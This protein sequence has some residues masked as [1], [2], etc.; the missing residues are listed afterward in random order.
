MQHLQHGQHA[1]NELRACERG[2]SSTVAAPVRRA[3]RLSRDYR[4]LH[5]HEHATK[6]STAV[7]ALSQAKRFILVA[8]SVTRVR[9]RSGP[10][11][12]RTCPPPPPGLCAASHQ[13]CAHRIQ[14]RALPGSRLIHGLYPQ[15]AASSVASE[16]GCPQSGCSLSRS[17]RTSLRA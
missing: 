12:V 14:K 16:S 4:Q 6:T 15:R 1:P 8:A 10:T 9:R 11:P 13:P 7:S 5:R 3:V 2:I 17:Q